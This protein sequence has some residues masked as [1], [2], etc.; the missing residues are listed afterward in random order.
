MRNRAPKAVPSGRAARYGAG[1]RITRNWSAHPSG[2]PPSGKH[3]LRRCRPGQTATRAPLRED[4]SGRVQAHQ[5]G[6]GMAVYKRGE[7]YHYEFEYRGHRFRGSTGCASRREAEA[8]E[9][10]K[11]QGRLR[12]PNVVKL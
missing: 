5:P 1:R 2:A 11:R 9:R 3:P 6:A 10:A 12:K 7:I 4:R 8:V